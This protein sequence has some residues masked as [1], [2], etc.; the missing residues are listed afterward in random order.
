[1][2][3]TRQ[4]KVAR[5]VQRDLSDIFQK[6]ARSILPGKM[7]T[8]TTVRMSPDLSVAK[9]YLSIFPSNS[10]KEDLKKVK[11]HAGFIRRELGIRAKN[12]LRIIPELAFFVDDSLD[13]MENIDNLLK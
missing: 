11:D 1:M 5:L 7:V 9:T 4:N 12:Q 2:S 3:T 13:Y 10:L 8:V 6:N